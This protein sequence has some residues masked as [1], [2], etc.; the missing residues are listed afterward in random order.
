MFTKMF[1]HHMEQLFSPRQTSNVQK[2]P[3]F[4]NTK[5]RYLRRQ[6]NEK[7]NSEDTLKGMTWRAA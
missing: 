2:L 7:M 4:R 5:F 1:A 6:K 3:P